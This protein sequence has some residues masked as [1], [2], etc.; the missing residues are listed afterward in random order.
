MIILS[1]SAVMVHHTN[2]ASNSFCYLDYSG[3]RRIYYFSPCALKYI[4]NW[5]SMKW[6]C[7]KLYD[8][9]KKFPSIG[10]DKNL[11][12]NYMKEFCKCL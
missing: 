11:C 6:M 9:H 3:R 10:R 2:K 1:R 7:G 4:H 5:M 8:F 12:G